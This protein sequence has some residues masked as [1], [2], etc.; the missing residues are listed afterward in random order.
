MDLPL[1]LFRSAVNSRI[2][3][4]VVRNLHTP[5][6]GIASTVYSRLSELAGDQANASDRRSMAT[7]ANRKETFANWPHMDYK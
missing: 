5:E 3:E 1:E 6:I 4:C 2:A 7:E